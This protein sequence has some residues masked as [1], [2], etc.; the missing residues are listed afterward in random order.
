MKRLLLPIAAVAAMLL[1]ATSAYAYHET[2]NGWFLTGILYYGGDTYTRS[3]TGGPSARDSSIGTSIDTFYMHLWTTNFQFVCT[4][5]PDK[6][7]YLSVPTFGGT[8]EHGE[9]D[10][11]EGIG[12]WSGI[13]Y[14]PG[15]NNYSIS[16]T[17]DTGGG[18]EYFDYDNDPPTY[19]AGWDVTGGAMGH[20]TGGGT[21]DGERWE[22][23]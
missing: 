10:T 19:T 12:S 9:E 16:G 7:I 6:I 23:W 17:W 21:C 8:K 5:D 2:W 3:I 18:T 15:N 20:P 22:Y 14:C 11:K 1:T 4:T 13:A